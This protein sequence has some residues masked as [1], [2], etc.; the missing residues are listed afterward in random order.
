M[1]V[2]EEQAAELLR[3]VLN[4]YARQMAILKLAR[5]LSG[6]S[7]LEIDETIEQAIQ[8]LHQIPLVNDALARKDLSQIQAVIKSVESIAVDQW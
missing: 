3:L 8:R 1:A 4:M 6:I 5:T 2:T 7:E